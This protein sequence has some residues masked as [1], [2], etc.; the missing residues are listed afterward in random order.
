MNCTLLQDLGIMLQHL[1]TSTAEVRVSTAELR[2]STAE[3][4]VSTAVL[5]TSTAEVRVSNAE[6]CTSTAE[7][8]VSTAEVRVSTAELPTS[9][10]EVRHFNCRCR[11]I[12]EGSHGRETIS[13]RFYRSKTPLENKLYPPRRLD[14]HAIAVP[15]LNCG[16][17][18]LNSNYVFCIST[19]LN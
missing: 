12:R 17:P 16:G 13:N 4:R 19:V 3:V 9:I 11:L 8:R 18:L 14:N 6:I 15:H 7:V 1:R 5:L 2:V 10:V